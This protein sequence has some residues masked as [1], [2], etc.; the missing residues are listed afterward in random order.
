[1]IIVIN[2]LS[3]RLGGGQTYLKNLLAHLPEKMDLKI[4]IFAPE[5]LLLPAD[6]RIRRGFSAWPTE[7]PVLRA[8]WEI[9]FLPG[10][11]K[12][13]KA[14]VLFCPGGIIVSHIPDGCKTV[15]MFQ[16]MIPFDPLVLARIPFGWQKIRNFILKRVMLR[17]MST[18]DLT[19]FIS[20]YARRVIQALTCFRNPVTIPHGIGDAFRTHSLIIP[21]PTWLPTGEY[22]LYVSRFDVYKHQ[23]EVASGFAE[24]PADLSSRYKLLLVG[25]LDDVLVR[26]VTELARMKGLESQIVVVGP[27]DYADLPAAYHHATVNLFA[28]SCENCPN[29]LLEALGA[30]RPVLSSDVMPMPEF[31]VDAVDYFS[32]TNSKSI[33]DTLVRVLR[34][35]TRR[36]E[37]A[38]AAAMRSADFDWANTSKTTWIHITGLVTE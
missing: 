15:T 4:I 30:G 36:N 37:L 26:R 38:A 28:S 11:L 29:I 23:F 34:N 21:R 18:A 6:Y 3:A 25:E 27:I 33:C 20:D 8:L 9:F 17:S 19:I 35:E 16:N 22:L 24:M 7:N 2:A 14:Q 13:E 31:G 1:M 12:R 5:S 10:I 32:P